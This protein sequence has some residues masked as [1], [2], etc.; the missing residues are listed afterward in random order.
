MSRDDPDNPFRLRKRKTP[1]RH[2]EAKWDG[3]SDW[4]GLVCAK[5]GLDVE[6]KDYEA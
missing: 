1:C 4:P 6:E 5:C 2:D 3:N